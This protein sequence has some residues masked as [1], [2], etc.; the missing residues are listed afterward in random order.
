MLLAVYVKHPVRC[1]CPVL[2]LV[3]LLIACFDASVSL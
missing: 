1:V 3:V 2:M